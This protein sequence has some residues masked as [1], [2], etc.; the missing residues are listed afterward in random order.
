MAVKIDELIANPV[1]PA[2]G[3]R[4]R[5]FEGPLDG[6]PTAVRFFKDKLW[7]VYQG[8]DEAVYIIYGLFGPDTDRTGRPEWYGFRKMASTVCRALGATTGRALPTLI[9]ARGEDISWFELGN[10]GR[11]I[12][13]PDYPFSTDGGQWFGTTMM[14]LDGLEGNVRSASFITENCGASDSWQL[15]LSSDEGGYIDIG[16]AVIAN[17]HQNVIPVSGGVPLATVAFH[18]LKPRLTQV[19]SSSSAPPQIRGKL[20]VFYDERSS[21]VTEVECA[22]TV[23]TPKELSDLRALA[24]H[25]QAAPVSYSR[26]LDYAPDTLAPNVFEYAVVLPDGVKV[27]DAQ[28]DGVKAV[29]LK[30]LLWKTA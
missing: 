24:A 23:E 3:I 4:G 25:A 9:A 11:D 22:V 18:N 10:R 15:A 16:A 29:T 20:V 6:Y 5:T 26:P 13:D 21:T 2:E 19:A 14:R 1:G 8:T 27:V 17:G 7:V 28:P 30:I 12:A